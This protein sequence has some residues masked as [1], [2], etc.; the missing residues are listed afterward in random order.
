MCGVKTAVYVLTKKEITFMAEANGKFKRSMRP[1]DVWALALGA[2]IGWG[3]FVLPGNAFLP[4]AGPL[5][6]R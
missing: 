6:T 4:K 1:L 2:I 3:C 5:G